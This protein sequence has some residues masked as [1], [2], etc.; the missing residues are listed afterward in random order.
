MEYKDLKSLTDLSLP[1]LGL[2]QD[3]LAPVVGN[4]LLEPDHPG[5]DALDLLHQLVPVRPLSRPP[6]QV[7]DAAQLPGF[8]CDI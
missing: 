7:L 6:F 3:W 8:G 1:V 5:S 2:G 4:S